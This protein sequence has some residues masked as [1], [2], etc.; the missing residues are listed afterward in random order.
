MENVNLMLCKAL[1]GAVLAA[2]AQAEWENDQQKKSQLLMCEDFAL[3]RLNVIFFPHYVKLPLWAN[4][5]LQSV[6][7]FICWRIKR[8]GNILKQFVLTDSSAK[9]LS[10]SCR[11]NSQFNLLL[12]Y[13]CSNKSFKIADFWECL[14]K[15]IVMQ[16]KACV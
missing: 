11:M 6:L 5:G 3:K 10:T 8:L 12:K 15:G 16:H 4:S 13:L 14:K 1:V 7:D 2:E 9:L